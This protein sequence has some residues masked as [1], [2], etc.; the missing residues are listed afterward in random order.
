MEE[1]K[2]VLLDYQQLFREGVK[3]VLE[4]ETSFQIVES[5][6]DFSVIPTIL[7]SAEIDVVL[8]DI[9]IFRENMEN[10]KEQIINRTGGS[11]IKVIV[12]ASEGEQ[13]YIKETIK[14]GAHGYLLKEMDVF[15]FVEAIK[16]IHQGKIGRAHV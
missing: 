11:D 10:I 3:R 14:A 9:H 8:I 16:T 6:D 12:M 7:S 1:I 13:Y 5:T 4:S 2:I 15:T